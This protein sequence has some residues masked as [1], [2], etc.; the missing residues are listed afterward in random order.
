MAAQQDARREARDD[1]KIERIPFGGPQFKLQLSAA[2]L[3]AAEKR[4]MKPR[5]FNEQDGRVQRAQAA[6]YTFI[7]PKHARSVGTIE[8]GKVVQVVTKGGELVMKGFLMETK[9]EFFNEDQA[10]KESVNAKVDEAL[11]LGGTIDSGVEQSY[12]P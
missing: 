11:A 1:G 10:R 6:G 7:D 4:G 9:I 5:W 2:D 3:K 8:D 12:R